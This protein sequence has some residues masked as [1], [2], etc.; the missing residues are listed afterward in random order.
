MSIS[1]RY[2]D[3]SAAILGVPEAFLGRRRRSKQ[4]FGKF[5]VFD[6]IKGV[7][8]SLFHFFLFL[9]NFVMDLSKGVDISLGV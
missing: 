3:N 4:D 6:S 8:I 1:I 5:E 9:S 2:I 7:I